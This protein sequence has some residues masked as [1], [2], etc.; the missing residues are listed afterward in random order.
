MVRSKHIDRQQYYKKVWEHVVTYARPTK[1]LFLNAD[2]LPY[3][4]K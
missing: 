3:D 1:L 4:Y 2:L